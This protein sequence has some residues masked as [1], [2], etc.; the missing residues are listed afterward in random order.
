M[1]SSS[2]Y[3]GI[4][5]A[6]E[7]TKGRGRNKKRQT[8]K[9]AGIHDTNG[10]L[11]QRLY[12]LT[13]Q[14]MSLKKARKT[15]AEFFRSLDHLAQL[16][17]F[18]PPD[19]AEMIYPQN[20]CNAFAHAQSQM[21]LINKEIDLLILSDDEFGCSLATVRVLNTGTTL[22]YVPVE[23]L[24]RIIKQDEKK[25]MIRIVLSVF[26]YLCQVAKMP[27]CD[28]GSF[29]GG[30][31]TMIQEWMEEQPDEWEPAEFRERLSEIKNVFRYGKIIKRQIEKKIHLQ[32]FAS[33][34]DRFVPASPVESELL[35]AAKKMNDLFI[36]YPNRS[37][38]DNIHQSLLYGD[39][40]ESIP[41]DQYFSFF[42][43]C[44]GWLCDDLMENINTSFQEIV[45]LDEPLSIQLFHQPQ[46]EIKHDLDF[47]RELL[48]IICDL[49][50]ALN[51]F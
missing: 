3:R 8:V 42:W 34:V 49:A 44:D 41:P 12:P 7:Q 26:A 37:F 47:E 18:Q 39:T 25:Q 48:S 46:Q 35:Q 9:R 4:R 6:P 23:P 40:E 10:F 11:R 45:A 5:P 29:V 19:V 51:K 33:R 22:Y 50:D 28:E 16:Y 14:D 36:R 2:A 31:Y 15:E 27:F 21:K 1:L 32:Q 24:L 20:I 43:S 30:N 38:F 13:T 17:C